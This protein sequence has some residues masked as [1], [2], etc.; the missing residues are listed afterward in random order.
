MIAHAW[1]DWLPVVGYLG[2]T[3]LI[4][5]RICVKSLPLP[6]KCSMMSQFAIAKTVRV[7][8]RNPQSN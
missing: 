5:W 4:I 2:F 8:G 6:Q 7:T 1:L 3:L